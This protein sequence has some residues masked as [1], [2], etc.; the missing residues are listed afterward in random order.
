MNYLLLL[1]RVFAQ[2]SPGATP[3]LDD[4]ETSGTVPEYISRLFQLFVPIIGSLA[5]LMAIYAGYLYM[6]SQ[7]NQ[8]QISRAKDIILG[9]IFGVVLLFAIRMLMNNVVGVR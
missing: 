2:A 9:V 1:S 3:S 8:E 5:I 6:T 4:L 7:G